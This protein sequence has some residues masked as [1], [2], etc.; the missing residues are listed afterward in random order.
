MFPATVLP[1]LMPTSPSPDDAVI[2]HQIFWMLVK[3]AS[4]RDDVGRVYL[5][6]QAALAHQRTS[7]DI[8]SLLGAMMPE[9][10][11]RMDAACDRLGADGLAYFHWLYEVELSSTGDADYHHYQ[12]RRRADGAQITAYLRTAPDPRSLQF[13]QEYERQ[14][15]KLE[16]KRAEWLTTYRPPRLFQTPSAPAPPG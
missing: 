9:G 7:V 5:A 12:F 10:R 6:I 4:R 2:E 3:K 8:G 15:R 13:Q 16:K 14:R 11:D 1:L